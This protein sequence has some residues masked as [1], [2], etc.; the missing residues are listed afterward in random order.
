MARVE[1]QSCSWTSNWK[2]QLLMG[3]NI[4]FS[5]FEM[6][7]ETLVKEALGTATLETTK[8]LGSPVDGEGT[9]EVREV[10]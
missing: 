8:I 5:L 3:G 1:S 9:I 4:S 2:V 10:E 7:S 6:S